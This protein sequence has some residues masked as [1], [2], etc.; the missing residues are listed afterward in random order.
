MLESY[1]VNEGKYGGEVMD[2]IGELLEQG[3]E[4]L[5]QLGLGDYLDYGAETG[6]TLGITRRYLDSF[7][8]KLRVIDSI[9]PDTAFRFCG[10]EF[11][12]P[13]MTA[14]LSGL[15]KI[16]PDA[17]EE[18]AR[19]AAAAGCGVWVG[20]GNEDELARVVEV[21][22]PVVKIV[23]PYKDEGI[24]FT[25]L[26]AAQRL[27]CIAVGMDVD[28]FFGGKRRDALI[29]PHPFGP[30]TLA[31]LK[32]YVQSVRVPFVVKGVLS[33]EDALKAA[34][35]GASAIVVSH[36][37]GA[38]LD[39]TLPPLAV[40]PEISRELGGRITIFVDSG[41]RRGTDVLKALA[42]GA[43][44]VL[45]GRP[46]M[47]G[48]AA[49]GSDGVRQ[50]LTGLGEE[51]ARAMALTGCGCLEDIDAGIVRRVCSNCERD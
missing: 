39:Y 46:V 40:L 33:V 48:L 9:W 23:K 34:E 41:I 26:E 35:A 50:V 28:F 27:G 16:R 20:I 24:V 18:I 10:K 31:D 47:A 8:F 7:C 49:A 51:L 21:G 2:L 15:H 42:L 13:I 32:R 6:A 43:D 22:A 25:K 19:G 14:A 45:V 17:M 44:A 5:R 4:K 36:H 30:K 12:Y 29:M 3:E 1:R 38:V 37:G 11:K